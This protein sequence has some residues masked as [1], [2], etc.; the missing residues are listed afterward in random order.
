[1]AQ[2]GSL[3]R[4]CPTTNC[5]P[6]CLLLPL[7]LL[8][9]QLPADLCVPCSG[10]A[11]AKRVKCLQVIAQPE[12][13]TCR[14]Q[15]LWLFS[16]TF[17]GA[18]ARKRAIH[19]GLSGL[20]STQAPTANGAHSSLQDAELLKVHWGAQ[21]GRVHLCTPHHCCTH[22]LPWLHG[23]GLPGS[24]QVAVCHALNFSR[25]PL[26]PPQLGKQL[27]DPLLRIVVASPFQHIRC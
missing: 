16:I 5:L 1:M 26:K 10:A 2:Q 11:S 15:T 3:H 8:L 7:V 4:W 14:L 18:W 13:T 17:A 6:G 12:N 9:H 19:R 25:V 23:Q 21:I 24:H 20:H 22:R 27:S